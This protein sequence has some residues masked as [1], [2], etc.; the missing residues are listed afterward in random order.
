M[1]SRR[2]LLQ[3]LLYHRRSHLAVLLGVV[4]GTAVIGG[5]LVVGD[6]VRGSL[7]QMTLDRLGSVDFALTSQR[8]FREAL[9][10][11][12]AEQPK[13]NR[14]FAIAAPALM[15][16][17]SI[18]R[19]PQDVSN[20]ETASV[21]TR[22]SHVNLFGGNERLWQLLDD[23]SSPT[24]TGDELVL[25]SRVAKQLGA[26][27]GDSVLLRV[28]LPTS[29][30]RDSLLGKKEETVERINCRV[31]AIL[32]AATPA[33]RFGLQPNQQLPLNAFVS[34]R[35]LQ[36]RLALA[37]HQATQLDPT[38]RPARVNA[39]F[40]P[41][42]RH[43]DAVGSRAATTAERFTESLR[44]SWSL[45]DFQLRIVPSRSGGYL[46]L[47]SERMI[48]EP[49]VVRA[50]E[51]LG[52]RLEVVTSPVL[53]YLANE[54]SASKGDTAF[55]M[56][57]TVAGVDPL[58][59]DSSAAPPFG[60]FTTVQGE[61]PTAE[62]PLRVGS[63]DVL[64][65]IL[66][67][68]WVAEDLLAKPGDEITLKYHVVGSRGEMPETAQRFRLLGILKLDG[69]PADDPGLT[70]VLKGITD[71][72]SLSDWEQPFEMKLSRVTKRDDAYW[73][74]YR[75]TPKA[76]VALETAQRLWRSRYGE[77]TSFRFAIPAGQTADEFA[78]R[79][80]TELLQELDPAEMG[81]VFQPVK[82]Q[83]LQAASGTTD[84]AG[85]FVGFS[86]FLIASA[87]IL[88]GLL[89]RLGLERRTREVGLLLAVG[90]TAKQV[91][92]VLL[93]ESACVLGVGGAIGAAAAVGYAAV[94]LHGLRTW[95]HGAIGT[96]FLTLH[97]QPESV[98][99]GL[100]I[101]IGIALVAVWFGM[102]GI[103]R[104]SVRGML[105][106][107][108]DV[109][110][111]PSRSEKGSGDFFR[112]QRL[113]QNKQESLACDLKK[114]PD[115]VRGTSRT[116]KVAIVCSAVVVSLLTGL[117]TRIIPDREAF[118]GFS[119]PTVSFFVVGMLSLVALIS[120][121]SAW[122]A[123]DRSS[124]VRGAGLAGM[125]RLGV[126]NAARHRSRSVLSVSLIASAS[127]L[128]VAIAAGQRNPV[129]ET[130]EFHSGNGGFSLVA[131]SS[132]PILHDLNTE[133]GR[134]KLDLTDDS[135]RQALSQ[136]K[137]IVPFR[138]NPGENASCLNIFQ[139]RQPTILGVPP[140]MI[141][142]GGFKFVGAS[143]ANPWKLLQMH[144]EGEAPAEPEP[145]TTSGSARAS[146]SRDD[147]PIP[148][149]GDMNTL[150]YSLKVGVGSVITI[151]DEAN[152]EV[153]LRIA[154]MFDSSVFQGVLLMSDEHF[155]KL[156]PSRAGQQYFLVELNEPSDAT[157]RSVSETLE[158]K[159]G[160][161]GF[162]AERVSDRLANFLA[163][164]NTY[165][166]AFQTLGGLGLLLGT[167]GLATVMLRNVVERR[168]ELAL[169]RAVGFR[170][171]SVAWLVLAENAFLLL[172]GLGSGA[173]SALLAM[174]PHLLSTGADVPWS[175]LAMLLAAV[176]ATGLAAAAFAV[177]EAVRTPLLAALRAE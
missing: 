48:L 121:L 73:E 106:G 152:R 149:L 147:V 67:N 99:I 44:S 163:V 50:A 165:L 173:A 94:M 93:I 123:A 34:L 6:S 82:W 110:L 22:V 136:V 155:L 154:G 107:S 118:A 33:G 15:M 62:S 125:V 150:Q 135:S 81:L 139:T 98:A 38:S 112:S 57:S 172:C 35:T 138:V 122:L 126:R 72:K 120:F 108:I 75:A 39:L 105:A 40:L 170:G 101:A 13:L 28:E 133:R 92:R 103:E 100:A 168:S 143:D 11:D 175:S 70:P 55:S 27:V 148:V 161:F 145:R 49:A 43:D 128:I 87:A 58:W 45:A 115:P 84:F 171:G 85:L 104:S 169:L 167:I 151:R 164:Q 146:P 31:A 79:L 9:S 124:A 51:K 160:D 102:R 64:P 7:R 132:S 46:S 95:W 61:L 119:W 80:E 174:T 14:S 32:D 131:E 19:G 69:T 63:A 109:S 53:V 162:D 24:P 18:E 90:F 47:E 111:P 153:K 29:I 16:T 8:F 37:E 66:L 21:T 2:F 3:T 23:G 177:T 4:V 130:P 42:R 96:Q 36:E 1:T 86:F 12:V 159:L 166:S 97:V 142:R 74:K 140:E 144:R 56:Y 117:L 71:A 157:V 116:A 158:T 25:N 59:F 68:E 129:R 20:G 91:R 60:G 176:F 83:G 88:I 141:D 78:K 54:F 134:D 113:D 30:P 52:K 127:F 65:D 77:L 10:A 41:A 156:F 114:T 5:A 137:Q 76:F 89:F 26:S 17:A